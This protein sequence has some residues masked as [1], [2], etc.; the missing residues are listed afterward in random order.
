M[1]TEEKAREYLLSLG[2]SKSEIKPYPVLF[3]KLTGLFGK[4]RLFESPIK[5][6][7]LQTIL[8]TIFWGGGMWLVTGL[9]QVVDIRT[10]FIASLFFGLSTGLIL[11]IQ[12]KLK[13]KKLNLPDWKKW[14]ADNNH[15]N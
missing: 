9:Y 1:K 12:V 4:P 15:R 5:L 8:G 6:F 14:Q 3:Y 7:I 10:L 13:A 11:G 2:A